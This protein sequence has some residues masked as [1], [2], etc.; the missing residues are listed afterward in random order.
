VQDIARLDK[1]YLVRIKARS[2]ALQ[3]VTAV[4][5]E[6]HDEHLVFLNSD[7]K[8]SPLFLMEIVESW[9]VLNEGKRNDFGARRCCFNAPAW[10]RLR[11]RFLIPIAY[12]SDRHHAG[13]EIRVFLG[14][15]ASRSA[16]HPVFQEGPDYTDK[17]MTS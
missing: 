10:G 9:N 11:W 14:C 13:L 16:N 5:A 7:S 15:T 8:L 12:Q 4:L 6:I 3:H 17:W 2:V 1:T